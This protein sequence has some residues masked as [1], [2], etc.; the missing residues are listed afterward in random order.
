MGEKLI[1]LR[2]AGK[3]GSCLTKLEVGSP[4]WWNHEIKQVTC[5][6]CYS[7]CTNS[8]SKKGSLTAP[9]LQ[10]PTCEAGPGP[11]GRP[12][13]SARVQFERLHMQREKRIEATWGRYLAPIVKR[14]SNDPQPIRAWATGAWGEQW[15]GGN[16]E[17]L[18][19]DRALVLHDRKVP[20]TR[21]NIDHIAI[22]SSGVWV[23]DAKNYDGRVELRDVGGWFKTDQR[24]YIGGRDRT[25][26]IGGL[27]WQVAVVEECVAE[28]DVHVLP[29]LCLVRGWGRWQK[30]FEIDG[31][32]VTW[33]AELA[34][35]IAEPGPLSA[36]MVELV[37]ARLASALP[38]K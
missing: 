16:L 4:A 21:G 9:P 31:T 12:G 34:R 13:E 18:L 7:G 24:L 22:A 23:I 38:T 28:L 11:F 37:T 32:F 8:P 17:R 36:E 20:S 6:T 26:L 30:S 25:K 35:W 19:G 29:I 5:T 33:S 14:L 15:V 27:D 3:C 1:K 10:R 2:Y